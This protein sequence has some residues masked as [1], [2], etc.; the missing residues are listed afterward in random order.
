[1]KQHLLGDH[2]HV[3]NY[4]IKNN[5]QIELIWNRNLMSRNEQSSI[6]ASL[7]MNRSIRATKDKRLKCNLRQAYSDTCN[8]CHVR[9]LRIL[10]KINK[11]IWKRNYDRP[12]EHLYFFSH[13]YKA[14]LG[15]KHEFYIQDQLQKDSKKQLYY[16]MKKPDQANI[17]AFRRAFPCKIKEANQACKV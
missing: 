7:K 3:E 10:V 1:M 12:E 17:P 6:K 15:G 13:N 11:K 2:D 16:K 5:C 14:I 4:W 8:Q 9:C